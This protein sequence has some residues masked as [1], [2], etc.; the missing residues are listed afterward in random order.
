MAHEGVFWTRAAGL[1]PDGAHVELDWKAW[2]HDDKSAWWE[3]RRISDSLQ[4][5]Q[6]NYYLDR[7]LRRHR[8][9]QHDSWLRVGMEEAEAFLPSQKAHTSRGR[10]VG[11]LVLDPATASSHMYLA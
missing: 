3:V 8:S 9:Q 11:Q 10:D 1:T 7:W 4:L 5:L 6:G 2:L